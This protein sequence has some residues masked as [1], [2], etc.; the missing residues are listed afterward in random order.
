[1]SSGDGFLMSPGFCLS[2]GKTLFVDIKKAG[3]FAIAR[4]KDRIWN[5]VY[6]YISL[7]NNTILILNRDNKNL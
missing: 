4:W 5:V 2:I 7:W 6:G 1:M 3:V